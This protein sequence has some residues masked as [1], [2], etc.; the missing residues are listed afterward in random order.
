MA[1][2]ETA[3][4]A[5]AREHYRRRAWSQ[6]FRGL[7]AAHAAAPLGPDD[8]E[9]LATSAYLIGRDDDY[10]DALER[11]Y[12]AHLQCGQRLAGARCAFWLGMRLLMRGDAGRAS[13]W[14]AR[15]ERLADEEGGECVERGYLLLPV[16]ER[17]LRSG[18]N[19]RGFAAAATAVQIAQRFADA[20]LLACA[21]HQQGRALLEQGDMTRGLALL[22]ETML[23]VA[24]GDL[25]PIVTGLM[26]CSVIAACQRVFAVDRARE[27]T[28]ALSR[29]CEEQ[30]EMVEFTGV[31]QAHRAQILRM[32]GLW[33]EAL[34]SAARVLE[35]AASATAAGEACY[36]TA[37]I[38]R[39]RGE[40]AAAEGA[41]QDASRYG[42]EPQPGL[43]LLRLAQGR[44]EA[45]T[46]AIRRVAASPG[47]P[48]DR[49]QV[50]AAYVEI[51]LAAG[52]LAAAHAGC[53][54]LVAVAVRL[55]ADAVR[56]TAAYA[57]GTI[58]VAEH[59]AKAAIACLRDALAIWQAIDAPY[60]A[61]R[62]RL[63]IALACRALGD[64]DG[65]RLELEAANAVFERLGAR[66][67]V[68]HVE[69]LQRG[70]HAGAA[71]DLTR[72]ELEVLRLVATGQRNKEI[73]ATLALSEKTI[74]R[75]VSSILAKLCV[76]SRAAATAYAHRNRL[77]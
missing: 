13:G 69:T 40:L 52:D 6:A 5:R 60:R 3:V 43:A 35:V 28:F 66:P 51:M 59:D 30:S 68:V 7:R 24:G 72:R 67:D 31:C 22:D 77:L 76:S 26:Y 74:D 50:L 38:R 14:F 21:L 34:D 29:W 32:H 23:A 71:R 47:P 58:D 53:D 57:H 63:A 33:Q 46:A 37:E 19:D 56:A 65:V 64:E 54:E 8:L 27:W 61:A 49:V 2:V 41:Y 42:R 18:D 73:A 39:L 45:A 44:V 12:Q 15:G 9:R 62:T 70:V 4:L 25:S 1:Q 10:L 55:D 75:H 36:E 11:A 17:W 16:A 48:C 20:D